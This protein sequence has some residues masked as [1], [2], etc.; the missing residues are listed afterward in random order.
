MVLRAPWRK[1]RFNAVTWNIPL[2][3]ISC[4]TSPGPM[5]GSWLTSP[6]SKSCVSL[7]TARNSIAIVS[8]STIDN[9]STITKSY[10]SGLSSFSVSAG[11]AG[12]YSISLWIVLASLPVDAF[13]RFAAIPVGA[14]RAISTPEMR[15]IFE[16]FSITPIINRT[17]VVLPHPAPPVNIEVWLHSAIST[18]SR[19]NGSNSTSSSSWISATHASIFSFGTAAYLDLTS[20]RARRISATVFSLS[21]R[22]F[23]YTRSPSVTIWPFERHRATAA[24]MCRLLSEPLISPLSFKKALQSSGKRLIIR[25]VCP[26][27]PA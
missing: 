3:I 17:V 2:F 21:Y 18:A 7:Q 15:H 6:K 1:E 19:C 23:E 24:S 5:D 9:S 13:M 27:F 11:S 25:N 16:S 14:A 10:G 12:L 8:M 4:K 20:I 22:F 26:L